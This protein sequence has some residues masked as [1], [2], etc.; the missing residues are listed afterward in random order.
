MEQ[1]YSRGKEG[2][3]ELKKLKMEGKEK[4]KGRSKKRE[5]G[6]QRRREEEKRGFLCGENS[7]CNAQVAQCWYTAGLE[8]YQGQVFFRSLS[9]SIETKSSCCG[10]I[11]QASLVSEFSSWASITQQ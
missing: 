7:C 10:N 3:R 6:L 1:K 2:K 9:V 4:D 5:G 11:F 8:N